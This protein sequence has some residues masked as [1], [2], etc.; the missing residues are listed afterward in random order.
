MRNNVDIYALVHMEAATQQSTVNLIGFQPAPP[1]NYPCAVNVA[2]TLGIVLAEGDALELLAC[3]G[4]NTEATFN[5]DKHTGSRK[6]FSYT[7][8]G[9]DGEIESEH[10]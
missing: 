10:E 7:I 4:H 9:G 3:N 5:G 1:H 2:K 8:I 6:L